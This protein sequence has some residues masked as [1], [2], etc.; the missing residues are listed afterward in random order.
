MTNS[1]ESKKMGSLTDLLGMIPGMGKQLKDVEVD[2][3]QFKQIEAIILSMTVDERLKP[4]IINAS[5]RKRIATGSGTTINDVNQL[6]K[7]FEQM[8]KMMKT[9]TKLT[10]KGRQVNMKNLTTGR[11]LR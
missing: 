2:E 7:Q 4:Q 8:K 5:R 3:D 1:N 9:M 11:K 10:G 6:I